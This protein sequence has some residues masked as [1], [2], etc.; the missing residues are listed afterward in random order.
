MHDTQYYGG[1]IISLINRTLETRPL[2]DKG[3]IRI[4]ASY[5]GMD[6]IFFDMVEN[7]R[8]GAI[9]LHEDGYFKTDLLNGVL[10]WN[11]D[12]TDYVFNRDRLVAFLEKC[13]K[14][15]L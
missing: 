10:E 14:E 13:K 4:W 3:N 1:E 8:R 9:E 11:D 12:M 5:D 2:I 6:A 7:N 15:K